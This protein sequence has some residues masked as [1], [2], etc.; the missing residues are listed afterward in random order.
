MIIYVGNMLSKHGSSINFIELLVPKLAA[1]FPIRAASSKKNKIERLLDMLLLIY[2]NRSNVKVVLIDTYS[3]S[4]FMY[5]YLAAKLC[6]HFSLPYIPI[7]HGGN[8]PDKFAS[9]ARKVKSFLGSAQNIV[10]PSIYL[11]DF[12]TRQGFEIT[13][14][15]NFIELGNYTY[16]ERREVKPK[17]LWVRAFHQVYNPT[18][19]IETLK[20]LIKSFPEAELCMVGAAKDDSFDE[21]KELIQ[22][23]NLGSSVRL[24]GILTKKEWITL[25][26]QY[27]IFIN[28][29]TIDNMP[30]SVIEAMA[31][32]LPIVSTN[33]GGIPFLIADKKD[34]V[35]VKSGDAEEMSRAIVG[36]LASH[37]G[38]WELARNA[39]KK[40]EAFAWD[41]VEEKWITLVKESVE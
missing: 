8:L 22:R 17:L 4:A 1:T 15:P 41:V 23:Y 11:Q 33:V 30:I 39:R 9:D 38:A 5:A 18:L 25:S 6:V 16:L 14:I 13:F 19:A 20:R 3:T 36:L 21:T 2:R 40:V 29:T 26:S 34:G 31:L 27:D 10:S 32:G 7:L 24:T 35:L 37:D 28:T 12:F